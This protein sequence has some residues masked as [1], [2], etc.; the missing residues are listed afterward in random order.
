MHIIL[1]NQRDTTIMY[2]GIKTSKYESSAKPNCGFPACTCMN[3]VTCEE[4]ILLYFEEQ[5]RKQDA[6]V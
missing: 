5:A 6:S 2:C 4:C 1:T 3:N